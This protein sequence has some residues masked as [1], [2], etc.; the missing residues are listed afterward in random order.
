[1]AHQGTSE[2]RLLEDVTQGIIFISTPHT[3]SLDDNEWENWKWIIKSFHKD[4]S[5]AA[6]PDT[7]KKI[8]AETCQNFE[9]LNLSVPVLSI[10]EKSKSQFHKG[11]F[12]LL[13]G[14][15][16]QVVS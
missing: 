2:E 16:R 10:F 6:L 5:K 3:T 14:T 12:R 7:D 11:R 1:M 9:N 13:G 8:L 15:N 4:A